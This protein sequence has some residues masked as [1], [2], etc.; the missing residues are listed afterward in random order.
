MCFIF[1]TIQE[2]G[3]RFVKALHDIGPLGKIQLGLLELGGVRLSAILSVGPKGNVGAQRT[4]N[5]RGDMKKLIAILA[6]LS[7][8]AQAVL[9]IPTAS[10]L[11]AEALLKDFSEPQIKLIVKSS[12]SLGLKAAKDGQTFEFA[13]KPVPAKTTKRLLTFLSKLPADDPELGMALAMKS[14]LAP[15]MPA[16]KLNDNRFL[17]KDKDG[18]PILTKLGKQALLDILTASDGEALEPM[19][20]KFF[21]RKPVQMCSKAEGAQQ[22]TV[23]DDKV[24]GLLA[25]KNRSVKAIKSN[26]IAA[27]N[28]NAAFDGRT[29]EIGYFNWDEIGKSSEKPGGLKSMTGQGGE[30]AGYKVDKETGM[31]RVIVAAKQAVKEDHFSTATAKKNEKQ[32]Y[33]ASMLDSKMFTNHGAKIVRAVDNLI[34]IDLPLPQAIALGKKLQEEQGVMSRPARLYKSTARAAKDAKEAMKKSPVMSYIAPFL[35]LPTATGN[36][37]KGRGVSPKLVESRVSVD[38]DGLNKRGMTGN[39][40]VFGIID[41]G[42]DM[43]HAD[44]KDEKGRSR[45][46]AYM[47]FTGE[48]TKD[49]VGHGTHV[50]GTVGGNGAS[51]DGKI[52]GVAPD[53]Q[54]KVAKVFGTEGETDESVILAAMKWMA[55]Q[56]GGKKADVINMSLSGPGTPNVDPL[57][58]MANTLTAKDNILVVAAAGNEGPW[59]ST[60]GSPGNSRYALTVGG[61]TKEGET[62]FFSSRG[63]IIGRDGKEIYLKPDIVAVSGDVDLSAI[64]P[65][66]LLVDS[67]GEPKTGG[68]ASMKGQ[69]TNGKCVY[70]PGVIAPRSSDDPDTACAVKGNE[71]YRAMSGTSM[72]APQV[73]GGAGAL[74]GY[75]KQQGADYD[76]FH[77]RAALMETA[78]DMGKKREDQ[79]SGLMQGGSVASAVIDRVKRGIPVGNIAFALSMR[80][81]TKD[82]D[83]LKDQRRYEMTEIGLLDKQTGRIINNELDL[84]RALEEI[85]AT[86]PTL[87]V[88]GEKPTNIK[89]IRMAKDE[90]VS[91]PPDTAGTA[92]S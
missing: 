35:P 80:L 79:G 42:I 16:D 51:S 47:D 55:S 89:P 3:K 9:A 59:Q 84:M 38:A 6:A 88:G 74:I 46:V 23:E 39:G 30:L 68:L 60:V 66:T 36:E 5:Q 77:V 63:P 40:A 12:T 25:A 50:A 53:A 19:P 28:P 11:L 43:D 18:K 1:K 67:S 4:S 27:V 57:G 24:G 20:K 62:P 65:E 26:E 90:H 33:E 21:T 37:T 49:V 45:V 75:L 85:R 91:P 17:T 52:K 92:T 44:F 76:A 86:K 82:V 61:V 2:K 58:S 41:S 29:H 7:L 70:N 13:G 48:G 14:Y 69:T 64:Q 78:K 31:V 81:T 83:K 22:C 54:F 73:A 15:R 34:T 56:K 72:A 10:P 8:N 87:M 32:I 71:A